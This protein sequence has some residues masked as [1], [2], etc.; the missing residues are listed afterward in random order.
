MLDLAHTMKSLDCFMHVSTAFSQTDQKVIEER[1][2][3]SP[4]EPSRILEL[5]KFAASSTF[6][7]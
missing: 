3:P 5:V 7:W 6:I 2:Y 4:I 1:V